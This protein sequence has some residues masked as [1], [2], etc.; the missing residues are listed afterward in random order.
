MHT[1]SGVSVSNYIETSS[2]SSESY[3]WTGLTNLT[4]YYFVVTAVNSAGES[5]ASDEITATPRSYDKLLTYDADEYDG[6]G[7]S[8]AISGD[9]AIAGTY[10]GG[11]GGAGVAYIFNKAGTDSWDSGT[12]IVASDAA[13]RDSFGWS[14]AISEDYAIV[15][16]PF[17]DSGGDDAGAAYIF[18]RTGLNTWDSGTKIVAPDA[19][20]EDYF[21]NAV[22]I[23][24]DYAIV[25]AVG[26]DQGGSFAGAAYIFRRTGLNTWDSGTTIVAPD[27]QAEDYFG[28]SVAISGDYVLVGAYGEDDGG[29]TA[30]AAYI[31][32]R[33]GANSWDSGTRIKATDAD[34]NDR[35]GGSVAINGDYAAISARYDNEG[36][37][38]AGA[39]Y[40]FK[41]TP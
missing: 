28:E 19:Q 18:R 27:A 11:D 26:E 41:N 33:T 3:V 7:Y 10:Y 9:Y 1:S 13:S 30:G 20:A 38:D 32:Q 29:Y 17:E 14:V 2:S 6:I 37:T 40:I 22:A 15:G 35:F 31:F 39:V 12:K 34:S 23:S 16:S 36:G 5:D 25:G 21:G 8:T 24:S 4:A